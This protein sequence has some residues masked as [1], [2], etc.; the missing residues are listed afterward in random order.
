VVDGRPCLV[1]EDPNCNYG[2]SFIESE[3]SETGVPFLSVNAAGDE[4]GPAATAFLPGDTETIRLDHDLSPI[5][6][7]GRID[8]R[9]TVDPKEFAEVERYLELRAAV[10]L[11]PAVVQAKAG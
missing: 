8:G 7:V 9:L 10:L 6:G 3:L 5:V 2:G 4:Y 11:W 1:Y